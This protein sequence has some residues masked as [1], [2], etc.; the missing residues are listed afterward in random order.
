M[1][2]IVPGVFAFSGLLAGRVYAIRDSDGLTL[3][4]TGL[5]L[6]AERILRQ[7][8]AAGFRPAD[9]KRIL[10]THAHPD[11]IGGLPRL[12]AATGAQVITSAGEAPVVAGQAAQVYPALADLPFPNRLLRV[13]QAEA[14]RLPGTPVGRTVVDGEMLGEVMGGLQAILTPG[15]TPGHVAF[16]H[17]ERRVLFCGDAMMRLA[18]RLMLPIPAFTASMEE[19]R[20]SI[21]RLSVLEPQVVC[22]GHGAPLMQDAA[23][24]LAAFAGK[25]G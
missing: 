8:A 5:A 4:D 2:E 10:I 22:F 18:G 9:V 16:W 1:R 19:A 23:R 12:Q 24:A 13:G 7:L 21:A 20:R 3:I 11:H 6:A 17:P 25:H 14:R 15:H